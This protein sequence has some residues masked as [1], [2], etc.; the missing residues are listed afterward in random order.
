MCSEMRTSIGLGSESLSCRAVEGGTFT[1][2]CT[3]WHVD[4]SEVEDYLSEP[5]N[6]NT[7][8][9]TYTHTRNHNGTQTADEGKGGSGETTWNVSNCHLRATYIAYVCCFI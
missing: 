6:N 1:A 9:S 2:Y 3:V 5:A 4:D 7:H 8:C